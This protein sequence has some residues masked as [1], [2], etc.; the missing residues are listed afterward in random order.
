MF[1]LSTF[2]DLSLHQTVNALCQPLMKCREAGLRH[3]QEIAAQE[4][5]EAAAA[6]ESEGQT[7]Q[8]QQQQPQQQQAPHPPT[9]PPTVD[10]PL[11]ELLAAYSQLDLATLGEV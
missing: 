3:L 9:A 11:G 4:A 8:Q 7:H 10:D 1:L 5:A 6:G 2:Q